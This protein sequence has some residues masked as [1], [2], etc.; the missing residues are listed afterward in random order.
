MGRDVTTANHA[1]ASPP[2]RVDPTQSR[3]DAG[4]EK[5]AVSPV[6]PPTFVCFEAFVV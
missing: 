1:K 3:R 4:A 6:F 5:T 2:K